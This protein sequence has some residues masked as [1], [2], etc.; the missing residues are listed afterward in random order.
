MRYLADL[1]IHSCYSMA[2]SRQCTLPFLS[3]WSRIKGIHLLGTGDFTHPGW[4]EHLEEQLIS[5]DS[6]FH[7]LAES[8]FPAELSGYRPGQIET[9]FVLTAEISCI[10]KR[11]GAVRKVHHLLVVPDFES[12]HRINRRLSKIGNL[13]ADGRPIL[14]LDSRD[15][16]E[17]VLEST[18]EG[19]LVPAHVWTPWFSLFGSRSGFDSVDE[20]FGDLSEH[21]FALETGLSADPEM[22]RRVSALDRFTLV[23]NSDAHS[24]LKLGREVNRFD[25]GFDFTSLR[26]ALQQSGKGGFSGTVEFFPEEGKYYLDGHRG[27]NCC[28]APVDSRKLKGI[29]P[30]CG[31]PVTTGVL[32]RVESLADRPK[33]VYREDDPGF[34]RLV[35]LP[36]ILSE[37]MGIKTFGKK[38][39]ARYRELINRFG[40]EMGLLLEVP[41]E[42]ISRRD[43]ER[44]GEAIRRVRC[45][46]VDRQPGFDGRYGAI[47]VFSRTLPDG[48]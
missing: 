33:A 9:R 1:H 40:S 13:A 41:T 28:L 25:A 48:A 11:D 12:V 4:L 31:K 43:S 44:L 17:I 6:G 29:C 5:S 46:E 26:N 18:R 21:I 3:A 47:R 37:S 22:M 7:P 24:P 16:L 35:S 32:S 42:E 8:V 36:E 23:S 14:G 34:I 19:F 20:C 45:G 39:Q 38:V 2:T 27:C 30:E 15:L 10:Y